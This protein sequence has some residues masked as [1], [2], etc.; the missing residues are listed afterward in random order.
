MGPFSPDGT[1]V[2][3]IV[4]FPGETVAVLGAVHEPAPAP[5]QAPRAGD[6]SLGRL[7]CAREVV[8]F[9]SVSAVGLDGSGPVTDPMPPGRR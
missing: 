1:V 7:A 6:S 8:R 2:E 9:L 3:L 5:G 4:L